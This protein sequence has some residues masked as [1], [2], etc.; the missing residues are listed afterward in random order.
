MGIDIGLSQLAMITCG[1]SLL[2]LVTIALV[3]IFLTG[4]RTIW[5]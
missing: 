4:I 5:K 1:V 2:M 3:Y